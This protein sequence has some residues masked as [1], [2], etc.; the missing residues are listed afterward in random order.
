MTIGA[1]HGSRIGADMH[2]WGMCLTSNSTFAMASLNA[3][4]CARITAIDTRDIAS[5][6]VNFGTVTAAGEITLRIETVDATTRKPTGTLYDAAATK[7][8]TPVAGFQTVT[9][10][11]LPTAG[12]V[13]GTEYA[14]VLLTTTGGTTMTIR[15]HVASGYATAFPVA[16]MTASDGTTRSNFAYVAGSAPIATVI[17]EDASEESLGLCHYGTNNTNN[18]FGTQAV[19]AKITVPSGLHYS[20]Y[21]FDASVGITGTPAGDLRG[22]ILDSTGTLVSGATATGDDNSMI[23][24]IA[25]ARPTCRFRFT[26]NITLPPGTYYAVLDSQS[27]ANSSNCYFMRSGV[28]NSAA[29]VPQGCIL[30]TTADITANPITWTP[31]TTEV[32]AISLLI[33]SIVGAPVGQGSSM[34]FVYA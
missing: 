25:A 32:P 9:F 29:V 26:S 28:A 33:D 17:L 10:A 8:F 1:Q 4:W 23:G 12:L 7:A 27:S 6:V 18:I 21:G 22:R 3:G 24:T 15:S 2:A 14:I 31:V 20:V 11:S 16:L 34:V 5:V 30:A 13:A 19:A